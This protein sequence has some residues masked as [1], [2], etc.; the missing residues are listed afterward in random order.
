MKRKISIRKESDKDIIRAF[1]ETYRIWAGYAICDLEQEFFPLCDW[2][3]AY[4]NGDV[5]S[6]CL[7]FKGLQPPT[8]ITMGEPFGIEGILKAADVPRKV[9]AH[10]PVNHLEIVKK[11]YCFSKLRSMKRMVVTK[12]S[13]KPVAG[14]AIRLNELDLMDLEKLYASQPGTFFRPYMLASGVYYGLKKN[15][16]LV[17]AAGTHV[18]SSSHG[19]ACVGNV[20]THP[21]Y[22]GKGY[23]TVCTS[24]VL[25]ELLTRYQDV[26]LNV[27]SQNTP[28]IKIYK[29]LGFREHCTYLEGLGKLE[30]AK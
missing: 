20:F 7:Y 28:A 16:I 17:S 6:L 9:Y 12:E 19:M 5:I 8:Q 4:R 10:I 23:A 11:H 18:C 21:S 27:D 24:G 22:R 15:D 29:R 30:Q 2:Y 1:L 13:F 14:Q 25:R 3:T 26:I